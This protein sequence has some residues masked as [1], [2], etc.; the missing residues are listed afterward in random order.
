MQS[1]SCT[2]CESTTSGAA[3]H[4]AV[5]PQPSILSL[6]IAAI[7]AAIRIDQRAL[8]L[9]QL[10]GDLLEVLVSALEVRTQQEDGDSDDAKVDGKVTQVFEQ[11]ILAD[12][13]Q[14]ADV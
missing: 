7:V 13:T 11:V 4:A 9:T 12:R 6:S 2:T 14:Q 5:L 3:R 10:D 8:E 1:P